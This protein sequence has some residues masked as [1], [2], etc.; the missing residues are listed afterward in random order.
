LLHSRLGSDHIENMS[1]G[2]CLAAV[3]NTCHIAYSMHVTICYINAVVLFESVTWFEKP[4][5]SLEL[6]FILNSLKCR[7]YMESEQ[8]I[9]KKLKLPTHKLTSTCCQL[10]GY[11]ACSLTFKLEAVDSSE[12]LVEFYQTTSHHHA[13]LIS[14][15]DKQNYRFTVLTWIL[16][17]TLIFSVAKFSLWSSY[18]KNFYEIWGSCSNDCAFDAK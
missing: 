16:S 14:H 11:F 10:V 1:R 12:M 4:V 5:E 13:N 6:N 3:V 9:A 8:W 18:W 15:K 2:V 7:Y 17:A